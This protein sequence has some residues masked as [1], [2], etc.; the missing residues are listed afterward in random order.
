VG[1]INY[2]VD[3]FWCFNH[4][5]FIGKFQPMFDERQ[6]KTNWLTFHDVDI[7][8]VILGNSR[9]TY[10][11][12]RDV[13]GR[14][15]NYAASSMRPS[16]FPDYLAYAA[17]RSSSDIMTVILGVSFAGTNGSRSP[18]F[19]LPNTYVSRANSLGF[20]FRNL[21][22]LHLLKYSL[23]CIKRERKRDS[24]NCYIRQGNR[25]I[26]KQMTLPIPEKALQ[27]ILADQVALYAAS[28]YGENYRYASNI[29]FYKEM[30]Q[31]FP[32]TRFLVFITPVTHNLLVLLA[33]QGLL[34]EYKAWIADL[35]NH[36]GEVWNFMYL[37]SVTEDNS[38]FKDAHHYS[39]E[40]ARWITQRIM[41]I[42]Y[43]GPED[44]GIRVGRENLAE[45]LHF[46][47]NMFPPQ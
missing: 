41:E 17:K 13:P 8:T 22:N 19:E 18:S 27:K 12:T 24:H 38:F 36:F 20:R 46:L 15:F 5:A 30:Q 37:N 39:P 43:E 25:L 3:P 32:N 28:A 29:N 2:A 45:H 47:D 16:E 26:S 23:Q 33:K 1:G 14:A 40:V 35:V 6:Q 9:V 31:S 7:D 44:F 21:L 10:L 42:P 4:G 11:D 34:E